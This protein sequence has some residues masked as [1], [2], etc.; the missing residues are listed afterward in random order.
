MKEEEKKINPRIKSFKRNKLPSEDYFYENVIAG[1]RM[2]LAKAITLVESQSKKHQDLAQR[3][4]E[5]C[6]PHSGNSIRIGI[7]GSP[8]VGKS[9]LIDA[10][11]KYLI[12]S[13]KKVAVLAVD[14]SSSIT[15]GSILGDKT[16]MNW[17]SNSKN[18]FIR[19]SSNGLNLGGV[20]RN[21]RGSMILCESAGY[22]VIIVETVGVGQSEIAV[23]SM[24]DLFLLL[25]LPGAGDE[26]QGIKRGIV[27]MADI[28]AINK[29]DGDR[30]SLA[31]KSQ[32]AYEN[33]L[34]LFP[35]RQ[36][37]WQSKVT[38]CSALDGTGIEGLWL[39]VEA[40][41]QHQKLHHAFFQKRKEQAKYWLRETIENDLKKRFYQFPAIKENLDKIE[42][43]VQSGTIT[44]L[45]GAK[46]LLQ[47]FL[48]NQ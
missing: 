3:V 4:I 24:T 36:S 12:E 39:I 37:G 29:A 1:D 5:K 9:T 16:R 23:H 15:K 32:R 19:P 20:A 43:M 25:L 48:N 35:I 47:M 26:V 41:V 17:L 18:A 30:L 45:V 10:L 13:G 14:P 44:P 2:A 6:L 28:L 22:D 8:G 33:A 40:Y 38:Y 46:Q 7:T 21:T 34:H 11:G 42:E 31:K 27:E